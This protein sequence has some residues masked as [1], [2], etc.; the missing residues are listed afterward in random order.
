[1]PLNTPGVLNPFSSGKQLHEEHEK[2]SLPP[3]PPTLCMSRLTLLNS[4]TILPNTI[5]LW[6]GGLL[7]KDTDIQAHWQLLD[8]DERG[9]ALRFK[10]Q[11]LQH[12]YIRAHGL[13][14]RVLAQYSKRP[15]EMLRFKISEHGKPYLEDADGLCFNLSHT[16][17]N[18]AIAVGAQCQLGVDIE[19]C[20]PRGSLASLVEKCFAPE[21]AQDW[22]QEAEEDKTRAFYRYWTRKEAFVKATG[23][24]IAVGLNRCVLD[25]AK[26]GRFL[27]VPEECGPAS[28]W[29]VFDID[30]GTGVC[31][32]VAT[33]QAAMT[34]KL[35][36][37]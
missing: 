37:L 3:V 5:D 36:A 17:D 31:C 32:A 8:D 14:R 22:H 21:E 6:H 28:S 10:T 2:P 18:L 35:N 9:R 30:L 12:R 34:I 16:D 33:D 1:M 23:L 29:Q 25:P 26:P 13:L 4:L 24:G 11:Q 20:K 19:Q 7:N 15:P 27:S